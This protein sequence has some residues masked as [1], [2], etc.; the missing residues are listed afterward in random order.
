MT[1]VFFD[2]NALYI[3]GYRDSFTAGSLTADFTAIG[4]GIR[5]LHGADYIVND[6]WENYARLDGSA[7]ASADEL[8]AYLLSEFQKRRLIN[9]LSDPYIAAADLGGHRV[10]C[11]VPG[12]VD[13][14]SS[15]DAERAGA[16]IGLTTAAAVAGTAIPVVTHGPVAE[17]SWSFALG[18]VFLGLDGLLTQDPPATGCVLRIG[19]ATAP[20]VL[21]VDLDEP[22]FLAV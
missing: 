16:V 15:D 19:R 11:A 22:Y 9:L 12:G 17:P 7:F 14:A 2:T 13:L 3:E 5:V 20:T 6:A 21:L 18:P 1:A 4:V 10:V 8:M